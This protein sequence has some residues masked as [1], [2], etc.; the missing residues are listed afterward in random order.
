MSCAIWDDQIANNW[1]IIKYF[2]NENYSNV[3]YFS[4]R[5]PVKYSILLGSPLH[6]LLQLLPASHQNH[7]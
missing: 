5:L 7:N 2:K 1:N 4:L 6:Y 3:V